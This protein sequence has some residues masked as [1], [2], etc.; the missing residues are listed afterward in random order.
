MYSLDLNNSLCIGFTLL[1]S[2]IKKIWLGKQG[3]LATKMAWTGFHSFAA[4]HA[5]KTQF[6]MTGI[7]PWQTALKY[8]LLTVAILGMTISWVQLFSLWQYVIRLFSSWQSKRHIWARFATTETN[9]V[10]AILHWQSPCLR[11]YIFFMHDFTSPK[12]IRDGLFMPKLTTNG[13]IKH[14]ISWHY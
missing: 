7:T 1:R 10:P 3:G 13:H 4:Y 2:R 8:R 14:T 9:P 6:A 12:T 11:N 5:P